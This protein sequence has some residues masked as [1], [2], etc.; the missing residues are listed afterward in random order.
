M[1]QPRWG[2]VNGSDSRL[3]PAGPVHSVLDGAEGTSDQLWRVFEVIL[4]LPEGNGRTLRRRGLELRG[5]SN[6]ALGANCGKSV[7]RS[8]NRTIQ[9]RL[10]PAAAAAI[11]KTPNVGPAPVVPGMIIR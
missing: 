3:S 7:L 8:L 6:H 9:K 5:F 10:R 4:T 11:S 1:I 2:A